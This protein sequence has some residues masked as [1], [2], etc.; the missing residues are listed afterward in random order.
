MGIEDGLH[1][2]RDGYR[3][4]AQEVYRY[5]KQHQLLKKNRRIICFG[6]SIT[7]GAFMDG[8]GTAEGDTYPAFLKNLLMPAR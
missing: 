7:Y 4:I 2:T 8:K 1:P 3:L 5:L 6:D